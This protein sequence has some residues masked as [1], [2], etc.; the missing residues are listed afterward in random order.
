[1]LPC[2]LLKLSRLVGTRD[3]PVVVPHL[4]N[5]C[6]LYGPP[7]VAFK[8]IQKFL[9]ATKLF[10]DNYICHSFYSNAPRCIITIFHCCIGFD[11]LIVKY[12]VKVCLK[13]AER[14]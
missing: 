9:Y 8:E 5:C 13:E 2:L 11:I 3:F 7:L 10:I 1:M 4:C 14:K 12:L 6:E